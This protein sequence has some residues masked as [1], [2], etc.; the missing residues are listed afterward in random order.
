VSI[1]RSDQDRIGPLGQLEIHL[2]RV[3]WNYLSI[4]K[5]L[6]KGTDCAAVVKADAYGLGAAEV[7]AELYKANCRHFYVAHA[8][9]GVTV[10]QA[11]NGQEAQ[12]YVLHGPL[13]M[14]AGEFVHHKLI[15]VLNSWG[16]IEYWSAF[17]KATGGRLPAV[18]QI[19]TGMNRLGLA[20]EEVTRLKN[21][22]EI[23]KPLDIRYLLSHLACADE[24]AHPKNKEQ[25]EVFRRLTGQLGLPSRLSFANSAGVFLGADYH[26]DQA[27]PGAAL[28]GIN[29][30]NGASN[31][32]HGVVTFKT[33]ILQIKDVDSGGTVGYGASYQVSTPVKLA[34]LSAGYADGCLRS[35][36]GNGVVYVR[37]Q[38]CPVIGR[39]SMDLLA[40]DVTKVMPLPEA[41]ECAEI[42]GEHQTVNDV[43]EAAKTIGYEI[44]TSLGKRYKRI[45]SGQG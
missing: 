22:P 35:L 3:R 26:F 32:M 21:N 27:R 1:P 43:A 20:A 24:P 41:G 34:I 7:A 18:I 30:L 39:V 4:Q 40:V 29:P 15:P 36:A 10:R 33:R 2:D 13:G 8:S 37:G 44:L 14:K 25:L 16:D 28:Y 9:E 38:K 11:L 31:P 19:D 42:I 12:I 45:Y 5:S 17:A 23:L 6:S